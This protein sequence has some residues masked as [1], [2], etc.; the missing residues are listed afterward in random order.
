MTTRVT[1]DRFPVGGRGARGAR[2]ARGSKLQ[3]TPDSSHGS[4]G[5]LES[6]HAMLAMLAM[7]ATTFATC[8]FENVWLFNVAMSGEVNRVNRFFFSNI[9]SISHNFPLRN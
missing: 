3:G 7:F 1:F 6:R 5:L 9:S 2:G 4:H 8:L